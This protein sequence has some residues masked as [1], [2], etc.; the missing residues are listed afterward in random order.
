M[1][2]RIQDMGLQQLNLLYHAIGGEIDTVESFSLRDALRKVHTHV[3]GYRE[4]V[5]EAIALEVVETHMGDGFSHMDMEK[6]NEVREDAIT[7]V[8]ENMGP[9]LGTDEGVYFRCSEGA[10]AD[11]KDFL[12]KHPDNVSRQVSGDAPA[13]PSFER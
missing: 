8:L 1:N 12:G 7:Y 6:Q 11:A 9:A 3:T 10:S 2:T 13:K 4:D 5:L